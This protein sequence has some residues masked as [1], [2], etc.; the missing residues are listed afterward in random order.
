MVVSRTVEG[1]YLEALRTKPLA[2][3]TGKPSGRDNI[4][5][6]HFAEK[7][8]PECLRLRLFAIRLRKLVWFTSNNPSRLVF[9]SVT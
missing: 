8:C 6:M 3:S 9:M 5:L 1:K 7:C 2:L 4:N